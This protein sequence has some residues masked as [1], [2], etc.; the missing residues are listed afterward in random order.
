MDAVVMKIE[1]E[2]SATRRSLEELK[3]EMRSRYE[4]TRKHVNILETKAM[5]MEKKLEEFSMQVFT[6]MQNMCIS[7]L[8]PQGAQSTNWKSYWQE[9]IKILSECRSHLSKTKTAQ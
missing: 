1:E 5:N 9:Q 3:E 6:T 4:E 7:L 2:S 8:D